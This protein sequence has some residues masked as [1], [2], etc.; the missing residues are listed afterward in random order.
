MQEVKTK[1]FPIYSYGL[2]VL[3]EKAQD[4]PE[5]Y[6]GLRELV[7]SMFETMYNASGVGLA[8]PQIGLPLRIF[9][10][11]SRQM[12]DEKDV[13]Q[14]KGLKKA[15][16]NAEKVEETGKVWSYKEGCLSIPGISE[17]VSRPTHV[18]LKY[19]DEHFNEYEE[20]FDEI[21]ARVIQ[22]EYD[23]IEG[24]LFTDHLGPL[25]KRKVSKKLKDIKNGITKAEYKMV[26]PKKVKK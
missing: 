10:I 20:V 3:K 16:I 17:N 13:E 4:I 15:F 14:G 22:H 25:K 18:K 26:F 21:T 5:D 9:V 6:E 23:H 12:Y 8:G 7:D 19:Y 24:V 2:D 1:I 11:D